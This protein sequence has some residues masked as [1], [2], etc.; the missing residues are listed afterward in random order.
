MTSYC[1]KAFREFHKSCH[2]FEPQC[3]FSEMSIKQFDKLFDRIMAS[4]AENVLYWKNLEGDLLKSA[5]KMENHREQGTLFGELEVWSC[6]GTY[7]W[8]CPEVLKFL[9]ESGHFKML[10]TCARIK[11]A[12]QHIIFAIS[13]I[14]NNVLLND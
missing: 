10:I 12:L 6:S 9:S 14:H 2:T 3:A 11:Q 1:C 4:H 8:Q 5:A 13:K 7:I